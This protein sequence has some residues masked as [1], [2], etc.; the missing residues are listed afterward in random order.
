VDKGILP[1]LKSSVM[2]RT[3]DVEEGTAMSAMVADY[4]SKRGNKCYACGA[5]DLTTAYLVE[6]AGW[7]SCQEVYEILSPNTWNVEAILSHPQTVQ[8]AFETFYE[9]YTGVPTDETDPPPVRNGAWTRQ[10]LL[11]SKCHAMC[12]HHHIARSFLIESIYAVTK[13]IKDAQEDRT[14]SR[15]KIPEAV[16]SLSEGVEDTG[17]VMAHV[18]AMLETISNGAQAGP[19][20]D[21]LADA[22]TYT[23]PLFDEELFDTL[24]EESR[25]PPAAAAAAAAASNADPSEDRRQ[26]Q[27]TASKAGRRGLFD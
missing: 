27:R 14:L 4:K 3:I 17:G 8:D 24:K 20:S 15:L 6:M 18:P 26:R 19:D 9:E 7:E 1:Y 16:N 21:R 12:Q 22:M 11:G 25:R 5:E 2:M 13:N 23:E 10:F